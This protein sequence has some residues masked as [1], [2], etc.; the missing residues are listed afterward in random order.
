MRFALLALA[1]AGCSFK[2]GIRPGSGSGDG[3]IDIDAPPPID[4][5]DGAPPCTPGFLDLCAVPPPQNPLVFNTSETIMT[6]ND[7]RCIVVPQAGGGPSVCLL[8]GTNVNVNSGVTLTAIGARPLAFRSTSTMNIDGTIDVSSYRTR[9]TPGAG[10]NDASCT[11]VT[12]PTGKGGGSGGG[13]GGSLGAAGGAGGTGN[14]DQTS[15][16]PM[17]PGGMP[18]PALSSLTV[19]R[20]G[21]IGQAGADWPGSGFTGGSGGGSGGALYLVAKSAITINGSGALRATGA[22]GSGGQSQSG[23]GGAG[24]GGL[25]VLESPAIMVNGMV[26]ANGGGGG[27][28]GGRQ[29]APFLADFTGA[30]GDDG[31]YG[32]GAAAGGASGGM[33]SFQQQFLGDGGNGGASMDAKPGASKETGAGGGGGSVGIVHIIGASNV[34]GVVSPP[35]Q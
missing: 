21:C 34:N 4:A 1:L 28:G 25:I 5:P 35:P 10:A 14:T 16:D 33:G 17:A 11:F 18:G 32:T 19:L 31:G 20:G 8:Q 2:D 26:S 30:G 13:A 12:T 22:G 7:A 15:G 24:S 9:A 23:G 6:D 27:E 29:V 3:G